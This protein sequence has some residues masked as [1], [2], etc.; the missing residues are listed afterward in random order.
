MTD[1]QQ[2]IVLRP[3]FC[4]YGG[5]WRTSLHYPSPK[6]KRII[7]PFAGAA[8][9][10][11]RYAHMDITLYEI[12]PALFKL[13]S[14]LIQVSS[15]EIRSLPNISNNQTVDDLNISQ[16]AKWLIGFWINKGTVSPAKSPSKWMRDGIRPNSQWG[17]A[18]RERIAQQVEYIRHWKIIN[19]SFENAENTES[20]WFIDP[21]YQGACGR[22]YKYNK[23]NFDCLSK[24]CNSRKG[25]V[26]VC[27]Q[28]GANWLPFT[29]FRTIKSLEGANGKK[30]SKEV[31]WTQG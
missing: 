6:Y 5:K 30:R 14:W 1:N 29:E 10:S 19:M 27:E 2:K 8:G 17:D 3:F 26:I 31:I 11:L 21:P 15:S 9:Y 7:E 25:Q 24:W 22:H 28:A 20:T 16:E 13:W 4:F 23:I 12:D 18:I